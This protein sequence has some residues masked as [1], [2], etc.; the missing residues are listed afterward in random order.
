L[1]WAYLTEP[2]ARPANDT[3]FDRLSVGMGCRYRDVACGSGF[4]A[5]VAGRRGAAVAGLDASDALIRIARAR[6]PEGD[7]RVGDMFDLPF[8]DDSFDVATSFN[9]IWKGCER[10][11]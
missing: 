10:A 2:Y 7:F 4:A 1:E 6:T 9:G 11:L 5:G 3:L 8:A